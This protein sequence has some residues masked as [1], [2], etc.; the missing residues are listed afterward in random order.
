[1]N[2]SETP[3]Q[4]LRRQEFEQQVDRHQPYN[5]RVNVI[6]GSLFRAGLAMI[7]V[8]T[9]ISAFLLELGVN[10]ALIGLVPGLFMYYKAFIERKAGF[11]C[12]IGILLFFLILGLTWINNRYVRLE[13]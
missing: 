12:A 10:K 11:A 4:R 8:A 6:E 1:M 3:S 7:S 9:V 2:P 5:F 13:K